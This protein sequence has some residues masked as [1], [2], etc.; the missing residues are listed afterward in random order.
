M[1]I[2]SQKSLESQDTLE[3]AKRYRV[4]RG[5]KDIS[6][7]SLRLAQLTLNERG[8]V[9][10]A[11]KYNVSKISTILRLGLTAPPIG[12]LVPVTRDC[13]GAGGEF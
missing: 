3:F 12:L 11:Q 13:H 5:T 7:V 1:T 9:A 6:P 2:S 10:F 4:R 8:L